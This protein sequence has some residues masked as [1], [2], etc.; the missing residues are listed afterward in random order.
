[1][2]LNSI[3][4]AGFAQNQGHAGSG[5]NFSRRVKV[6]V[7]IVQGRKRCLYKFYF[8]VS[9]H[10]KLQWLA[11]LNLLNDRKRATALESRNKKASVDW[12]LSHQI[13]NKKLT[14]L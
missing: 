3:L 4:T 9:Q 12:N 5:L 10:I 1:M 11:C 6:A 14:L 8:F 13:F 7:V 2:R